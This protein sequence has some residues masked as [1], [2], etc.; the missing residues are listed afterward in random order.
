MGSV[1]VA[2]RKPNIFLPIRYTATRCIS[3]LKL[4]VMAP[5]DSEYYDLVRYSTGYVVV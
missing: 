5:V 2:E 4:Q 1:V 3:L